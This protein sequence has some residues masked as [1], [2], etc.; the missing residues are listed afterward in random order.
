M[1]SC[2]SIANGQGVEMPP[3]M[4]FG[5]G[6][7]KNARGFCCAATQVYCGS[8][9]AGGVIIW[10][11]FTG[12]LG[13]FGTYMGVWSF[14]YLLFLVSG[15]VAIRRWETARLNLKENEDILR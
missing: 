5:Q 3:L 9:W 4:D 12:I 10:S 11:A 13:M 8:T 7:K 6:Y 15:G 1:A 14:L 2:I